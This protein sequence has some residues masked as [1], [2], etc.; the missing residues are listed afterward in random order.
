M[1]LFYLDQWPCWLIYSLG[2]K[3][4]SYRAQGE[5]TL[6]SSNDISEFSNSYEKHS[7]S[8]FPI[9][10]KN[11]LNPS[12]IDFAVKIVFSSTLRLVILEVCLVGRTCLKAFQSLEESPLQSCKRLVK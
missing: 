10:T 1:H 6:T 11:W 9:L 12:A 3:F 5:R 8:L 2:Y 4:T 7:A